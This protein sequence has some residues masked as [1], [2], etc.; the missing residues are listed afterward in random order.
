MY[1]VTCAIRRRRSIEACRFPMGGPMFR[2]VNLARFSR[3]GRLN[4]APCYEICQS[5]IMD[6]HTFSLGQSKLVL[7]FLLRK[8]LGDPR[9]V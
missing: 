2:N 8:G 9:A 1:D 6:A 3:Y 4:F 5:L 7:K